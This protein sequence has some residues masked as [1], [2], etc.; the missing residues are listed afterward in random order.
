MQVWL[1][2]LQ[3]LNLLLL[4]AVA[5][6]YG[7]LPVPINT[8]L[9]FLLFAALLDLGFY[10][11]YYQ[12]VRFPFSALTSAMGIVLILYS[13]AFWV[14]LFAIAAAIAQK[15]LLRVGRKHLFNPSNFGVVLSLLLFL[16]CT[17]LHLGFL[18]ASEPLLFAVIA[19]ALPLLFFAERLLLSL[20]FL[21]FY[22]TAQALFVVVPDPVLTLKSYLWQHYSVAFALFVLFMITDPRTTPQDAKTTC[23]FALALALL[24]TALDL[25]F[26][27]KAF[28]LFLAL[29][30][31]APLWR[32]L[33]MRAWRAFVLSLLLGTGV[34]MLGEYL[35][36]T[37]AY[38]AMVH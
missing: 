27:P 22:F 19:V 32:L 16:H 2:A 35:G 11:K 31:L 20:L 5:Y 33:S 25:I 18:G 34:I 1:Q 36:V 8:F 23:C 30:V 6:R 12:K 26:A 17:A 3:A 21:L 14:Y 28:H 10:Y 24:A 9:L 29:F 38:E 13:T 4:S 37:I 15:Y 7:T